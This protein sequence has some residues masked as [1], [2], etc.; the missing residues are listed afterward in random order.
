MNLNTFKELKEVISKEI[1]KKISLLAKMLSS[2]YFLISI[3]IASIPEPTTLVRRSSRVHIPSPIE[4][5]IAH[6][7]IAFLIFWVIKF[8]C[9]SLLVFK[10]ILNETKKVDS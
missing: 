9:Y 4:E 2:T 1:N 3:A 5:F 10:Q 7:F 6:L 8:L